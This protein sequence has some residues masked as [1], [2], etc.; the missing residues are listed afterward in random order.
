MSIASVWGSGEVGLA[1]VYLIR[2]VVGF[3]L[4]VVELAVWGGWGEGEAVLVAD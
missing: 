1:V 3:D 2:G 4:E